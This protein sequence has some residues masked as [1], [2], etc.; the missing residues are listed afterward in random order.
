[1][2]IC[3]VTGCSRRAKGYARYCNAH[4]ARNRRHGDPLQD[5]IT[6]ER[7]KQY[8]HEI[9]RYVE[10]AGGERLWADLVVL[11]DGAVTRAKGCLADYRAGRPSFRHE[12]QAAADVVSTNDE[13]DARRIIATIAAMV[14]MQA[15]EAR[16]FRS[17]RAFWVQVARRFRGLGTRHVSQYMGRDARTHRVYRDPNPTAAVTLGRWLVETVG[18]LGQGAHREMVAASARI[19][20][21]RAAAWSLMRSDNSDAAQQLSG[22]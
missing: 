1:M 21:A 20:E 14:W 10:R 22:G 15:H 19:A 6:T 16:A 5:T 11:W 17:D 12:V 8:V 9:E 18:L 3:H 2:T 4:R 13:A 7:L